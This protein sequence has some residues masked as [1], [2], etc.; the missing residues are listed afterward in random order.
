MT[1][2][3][4]SEDIRDYMRLCRPTILYFTDASLEVVDA[5]VAHLV[6]EIVPIHS[7]RVVGA[8]G[9]SVILRNK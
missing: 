4:E 3:M 6:A 8:P 5:Q 1:A 9:L 7:C 2:S